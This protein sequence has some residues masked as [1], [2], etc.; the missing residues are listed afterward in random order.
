MQHNFL[1]PDIPSLK[2]RSVGSGIG[3]VIVGV[4]GSRK[5]CS[6]R[7]WPTWD[8]VEAEIVRLAV[9]AGLQTARAIVS[10][11]RGPDQYGLRSHEAAGNCLSYQLRLGM[12]CGKI[13]QGTRM[14]LHAAPTHSRKACEGQ[15]RSGNPKRVRGKC[16]LKA[17]PVIF[18]RNVLDSRCHVQA[19]Y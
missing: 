16:A 7:P 1:Y 2:G 11:P 14:L 9:L 19:A 12:S 10:R 18:D 5:S 15:E 13:Q 3:A 8:A 4:A 17:V 6:G